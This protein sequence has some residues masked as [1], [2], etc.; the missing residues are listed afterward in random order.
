M[1]MIHWNQSSSR[2]SGQS[3]IEIQ[4]S[5][6]FRVVCLQS[7]GLGRRS[8]IEMQS[9]SNSGCRPRRAQ[10]FIHSNP[11][12]IKFRLSVILGLG[13]W[14]ES[15]PVAKMPSNSES[16]RRPPGP[17][18]SPASL[19]CTL[20]T[21]NHRVQSSSKFACLSFI[22]LG[23]IH[24]LGNPVGSM[25]QPKPIIHRNPVVSGIEIRLSIIHRPG[26]GHDGG[27]A[28]LHHQQKSSLHPLWSA[29]QTAI[30]KS[31]RH[32]RHLREGSVIG[33]LQR[34]TIIN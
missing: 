15:N 4:S 26:P 8:S 25:A 19:S 16:G 33:W 6:N 13:R 31:I 22:G 2:P 27:P 7:I 10:S 30:Q 9:S 12:V 24:R 11:V 32:L 21:W 14:A 1:S 20:A 34:T 18:A 23:R 17:R 28:P 3:S 29:A 5:S